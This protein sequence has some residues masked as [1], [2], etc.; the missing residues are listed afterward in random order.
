MRV[1]LEITISINGTKIAV[2]KKEI[3]A[4]YIETEYDI[5]NIFEFDKATVFIKRHQFNKNEDELILHGY[6]MGLGYG[7]SYE[8]IEGIELNKLGIEVSEFKKRISLLEKDGF[9]VEV[10]ECLNKWTNY[11]NKENN[12]T[13]ENT[14]VKQLIF[15]GF[16]IISLFSLV[17]FCF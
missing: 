3:S 14:T 12:K 17:L 16:T 11:N 13:K 8:Y 10:D 4:D 9:K 1:I 7:T 5:E 6:Y 15:M 2:L